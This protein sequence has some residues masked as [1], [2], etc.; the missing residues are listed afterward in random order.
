MVIEETNPPFEIRR[1]VV[2][3]KQ[4]AGHIATQPQNLQLVSAGPERTLAERIETRIE[5]ATL[6]GTMV[7]EAQIGTV[8]AFE[9]AFISTPMQ[10]QATATAIASQ[11][12]PAI[13]FIVKTLLLL[14]LVDNLKEQLFLT[15]ESHQLPTLR[16]CFLRNHPL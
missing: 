1:V 12:I 14:T 16:S 13:P 10:N 2:P 8:H 3:S 15:W 9:P 4:Q 11:N 5:I 6:E 7:A